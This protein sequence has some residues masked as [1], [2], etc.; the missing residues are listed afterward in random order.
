MCEW[1]GPTTGPPPTTSPHLRAAPRLVRA[2]HRPAASS[3]AWGPG[4]QMGLPLQLSGSSSSVRPRRRPCRS[5]LQLGHCR[6]SHSCCPSVGV[7]PPSLSCCPPGLLQALPQPCSV[8]G[9]TPVQPH[10]CEI[11]PAGAAA[12][13]HCCQR[14]PAPDAAA[15]SV[16]AAARCEQSCTEQGSSSPAQG[17]CGLEALIRDFFEV[18]LSR[19]HFVLHPA[20][21]RPSLGAPTPRPVLSLSEVPSEDTCSCWCP[22]RELSALQMSFRAALEGDV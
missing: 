6:C 13:V 1:Q 22:N 4:P 10:Q 14:T 5:V 7:G 3:Q 12:G 18:D 8:Q 11:L 15:A 20:H 21:L 19:S 17:R 9:H 2:A 16:A